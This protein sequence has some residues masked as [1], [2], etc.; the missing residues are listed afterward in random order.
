LRRRIEAV[1]PVVAT[2]LMVAMTVV[3]TALLYIMVLG[4]IGGDV[5]TTSKIGSIK[6]AT[7]DATTLDAEFTKITPPARPMDLKIIIG[8]NTSEGTY[9]FTS[10]GDG[11][12]IFADGIDIC[13]IDYTD[14]ADDSYVSSGDYLRVSNLPSGSVVTVWVL[15]AT[16]GGMIVTKTWDLPG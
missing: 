13:D 8:Y 14:N 9:S 12:L 4:M 3:L 15:D 1:S 10:N 16:T 5:G 6:L 2:I 7:V 11:E